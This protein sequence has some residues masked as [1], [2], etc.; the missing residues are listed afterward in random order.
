MLD[1]ISDSE[2]LAISK[3][4]DLFKKCLHVPTNEQTRGEMGDLLINA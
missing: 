3:I 4:A 1:V 2:I